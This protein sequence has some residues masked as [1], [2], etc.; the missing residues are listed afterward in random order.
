MCLVFWSDVFFCYYDAV[1]VAGLVLFCSAVEVWS[2]PPS[3]PSEVICIGVAYHNV[4]YIVDDFAVDP[5]FDLAVGFSGRV[6]FA[7]I[8]D[9]VPFTGYC[10]GPG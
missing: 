7:H 1:D 10:F 5:T 6:H 4:L 3:S 8:F 9:A 2:D